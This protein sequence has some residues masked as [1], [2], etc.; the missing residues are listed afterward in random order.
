MSRLYSDCKSHRAP[1][2]EYVE[3]GTEYGYAWFDSWAHDSY[4]Y[5]NAF[6]I[7]QVTINGELSTTC[8]ALAAKIQE[9]K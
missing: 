6:D 2:N 5:C 8:S 3:S 1:T 4:Y 7:C 9:L